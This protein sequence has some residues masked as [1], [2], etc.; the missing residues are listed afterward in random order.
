[1]IPAADYPVVDDRLMGLVQRG[2]WGRDSTPGRL[3]LLLPQ[4]R[5]QAYVERNTELV[6]ARQ[7]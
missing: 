2:R 5:E 3:L 7:W 6:N 4:A 1:M